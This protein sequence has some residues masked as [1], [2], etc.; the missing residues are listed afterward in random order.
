VIRL[1]IS[2]HVTHPEE[3]TLLTR[4]PFRY[5]T[6]SLYLVISSHVTH[7]EDESHENYVLRFNHLDRKNTLPPGGFPIY[8][9][10]FFEGGPL[11][12]GS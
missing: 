5:D 7:P 12:H 4:I 6:H 1:V 10:K 9:Y 8:W 3:Y 11:T 2:S